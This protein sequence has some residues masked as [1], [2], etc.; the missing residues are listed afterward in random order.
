M[1]YFLLY[2]LVVE[3]AQVSD[4]KRVIKLYE[5]FSLKKWG[6]A[7]H[8]YSSGHEPLKSLRIRYWY[9]VLRQRTALNTA[10]QLE[11]YFE[12]DSFARDDKGLVKYYKNK[13]TRYEQ[14]CHRPQSTLL[15]KVEEK[16]PGS[17]WD[18]NHPLWSVL[19]LTN[20][21]V[22]GGNA[23][24]RRLAPAV[25]DVLF[26]TTRGGVLGSDVRSPVTRSLLE[27]LER[28][29][30][31]DVLACLV[32]LLREASEKQT[33]DCVS[34]G[35][36]LHNVLTMMAF[37][38]EVLKIGLPLLRQFTDH[39]LPLGVPRYHRMWLTPSHYLHSSAHLNLR[40]YGTAEG[41]QKT[42]AWNTR[43]KIMQQL[44]KGQYGYEVLYAMRPHFELDTGNGDIPDSVAKAHEIDNNLR[45][46]G[47]ECIS[48]G[49]LRQLLPAELFQER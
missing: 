19:D 48:S 1:S 23:F 4:I 47:W 8:E 37:E 21:R 10:Y 45:N 9:E 30:C 22:M 16:A 24:L 14:G 12:P 49:K 29:A 34:I 38:L 13:W 18:L 43:V 46:W 2:L 40:V 11:Q 26:Q 5:E 31:L 15:T 36:A 39:I 44:L 32:W 17:T 42:L 41:N 28:R 27:K 20:L 33:T 35:N 25:Q 6:Y 7:S 3:F